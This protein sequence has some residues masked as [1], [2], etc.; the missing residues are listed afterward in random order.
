MKKSWEKIMKLTKE[1]F[2]SYKEQQEG[3]LR[4]TYMSIWTH[5]TLIKALEEK[6]KKTKK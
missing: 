2:K 1:D 3:Q 5:E 6:I 4:I